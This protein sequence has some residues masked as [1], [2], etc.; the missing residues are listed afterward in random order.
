MGHFCRAC[1]RDRANE[2]FSGRGHQQHVCKDCQRL[3]REKRNR[4]EQLD[5]LYS[6]LDQ[7]NI[8][9]KNIQRLRTL[10]ASS[11]KEVRA[12]AEVVREIALVY[13]RK[14]RRLQVLVL[15]HWELFLRW[16]A[17]MGDEYF[18]DLALDHAPQN[19]WLYA[20]L[21]RAASSP[22]PA[23]SLTPVATAPARSPA[24]AS[25]PG[26]GLEPTSAEAAGLKRVTIYTDGA[27]RGNPGPG[28]WAAILRYGSR[29]R[30][31]SGGEP[32]TT[33]NR[34]ELLAAISA[35]E[36][37]NQPCAVS[38]H[39]DSEYLRNGI[40]RWIARWKTNGWRTQERTPVKNADLWIRLD[41][42]VTRHRLTWQ[43]VRGHAGTPDNERCDA[44][45]RAA[46]GR[47]QAGT[48]TGEAPQAVS[49]SHHSHHLG[50]AHQAVGAN[51]T[52]LLITHDRH[53]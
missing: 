35:L 47:R 49:G 29:V 12:L 8:S 44:L 51:Q 14:R 7:S 10:G 34:M 39:T 6:F 5:E 32:D 28:G 30:E 24:P 3:P 31:I 27:C 37:L 36:S 23:R 13:P 50:P 1:R 4:T 2:R 21:K 41:A 22:K 15:A 26:S 11:D 45:A 43:W 52:R 25:S 16:H 48:T 9:A 20:A 53:G 19:D 46:V 18:E 33:N 40:T 38:I 17:V 42:A